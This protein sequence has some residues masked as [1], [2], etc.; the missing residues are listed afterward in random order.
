MAHRFKSKKQK[1]DLDTYYQNQD[2]VDIDYMTTNCD[3]PTDPITLKD[4]K[5]IDQRMYVPPGIIN[6]VKCYDLDS[7]I[8]SFDTGLLLT[9]PIKPK[10]PTTNK[11]I[12]SEQLF[13]LCAQYVMTYYGLPDK[14]SAYVENLLPIAE[15]EIYTDQEAD[16]SN[17]FGAS[18]TPA[19]RARRGSIKPGKY[20]RTRY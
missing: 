5:D 11:P 17:D 12:T 20:D 2:Y 3:D 13:Q 14:L 7:L 19:S 10:D 1:V 6:D 9:P 8:R 16:Q 4:W 18:H 15:D